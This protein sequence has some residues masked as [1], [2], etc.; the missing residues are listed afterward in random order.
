MRSNA[1]I[2]RASLTMLFFA[3]VAATA[4]AFQVHSTL[5]ASGFSAPVYVTSTPVQTDRLFVVEQQ[6]RIRIIKNG[7]TLTTPFL[8]ITPI[9][10][11]FDSEQGLLGLAFDPGYT[12]NGRFY[13]AYTDLNGQENVRRYSVSSNPDV[14]DPASFV[15]IFGPLPHPQTNHNGGN[16][17]FG[18]DGFLYYGMGDGGGANDTGTGHDPTTGNAQSLNTY[19]GKMLRMDVNNPPSYVPSTNPFV[20]GA[21]PLIWAFGLRNPWRW[22]FDK[23]TGDLYIADVGQGAWEE[24][25]FQPASSAGGENYG[26]RCMEGS[27]CTGL[28]GCTCNAANLVLPIWEYGHVSGQC[29]IIGGYVYRGAIAGLAGTYFF[30]DYCT[31]SVWSFAYVGGHVT[32]FQDRTAELAPGGGLAIQNPTSF[33]EDAAGEL[34]IVDQ[35]GGEI[36]RIDGNCPAPSSYCVAAPNSVGPGALMGSSGDGTVSQNDLELTCSGAPPVEFGLFFYGQGE[37]QVPLGNGFRCIASSIHRLPV[38]QT[39]PAGV[40]RFHFDV[41]APPHVVTAGRTWNFQFWYRDPAGGGAFFNASNAL[42][43]PFCP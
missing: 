1:S 33:G 30:A 39:S 2:V 7:I 8:D 43:V 11:S 25:D 27:H 36:F 14:A 10:G 34:Y 38:V 4:T 19:L 23:A 29:A 42:S 9:V 12:S 13:V 21:F 20:G 22:S 15:T 40:A 28:T 3:L 17:N 26:W 18:P 32:N 6:G 5:V 41:N 31:G 16:L 37:T 35:N 24:V